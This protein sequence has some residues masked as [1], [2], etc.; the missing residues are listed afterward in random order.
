[1]PATRR[2]SVPA[3]RHPGTPDPAGRLA[4]VGVTTGA[5]LLAAGLVADLPAPLVTAVAVGP[6][7]VCQAI[8]IMSSAGEFTTG[9][10]IQRYGRAPRGQPVRLLGA[11]V[12]FAGLST[13]GAGACQ[14]LAPQAMVGAIHLAVAIP[15]IG[16]FL[17][18]GAYLLGLTSI[19]GVPLTLLGRLRRTL[20]GV[21]MGLCGFF[22]AWMLLFGH[23]GIRRASLSG[24]LLAC[25][26]F[27]GMVIAGLRSTTG[28]PAALACGGGIALSIAGMT[29]LIVAFD[30]HDPPNRVIA[31]GI[32][33]LIAPVLL[34]RATRAVAV[35]P[36][37]FPVDG[38]GDFGGYPLFALPLVAALLAWIDHFVQ[39]RS[40]DSTSIGLALAAVVA[41]TLRGAVA[42]FEARR[43]AGWLSVREAHFRS[44][45]SGSTDVIMV[46]DTDLRIR[47]QSPAAAR[48]FG[49][50]D[51]D[52][53]GR[54]F[55]GVVPGVAGVACPLAAM[56]AGDD[57]PTGP[58]EG[59]LLD[60]FGAWR[61]VEWSVIDHR[62]VPAV[63]AMVVHLRDV[64]DRKRLQRALRQVSLVDQVTGLPNR[65]ELSRALAR[66]RG[67]GVLIVLCLTDLVGVNGA[68]GHDVGDA[69]L[70]E[71]ARRI[72]A[73]VPAADLPV[74]LDSDRFAVLTSAMGVGA[75][76]LA[77]RLL[78][79]LAAP[80]P[81][82]GE[83]VHLSA[84]AGLAEFAPGRDGDEV[85]RRAE[86]AIRQ[87]DHADRDRAVEWYDPSNEAALRR[88]TM[89]EHA[90]RG[91]LSRVELDLSYQPVVDLRT[92]RP[93]GVEAILRWRHPVL[94][95]VDADEFLPAAERLG[96]AD[97]IGSWALHRAGREL[98]GWLR[99]GYDVWLSLDV[100]VGRL[101]SAMFVTSVQAV[102]ETHRLPAQ[103]LAV[104]V[105]ELGPTTATG[106]ADP[107]R[108][109][110]GGEPAA[111]IRAETA[112]GHLAELRSMG[113][114][115]AL[116]HFGTWAT[117]LSG[118]QAMPV[119]LLKADQSLVG[120]LA[121]RQEPAPAIIETVV[122]LGRQLGTGVIALGLH[123]ESDLTVA[124]A[125]G[126]RFGQGDRLCRPVPA[127]HLEAYLESHRSPRSDA[128]T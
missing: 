43:F 82:P 41:V 116:D 117:S 76:F 105:A 20:D 62:G 124:R 119:D 2:R 95:E 120:G 93:I 126:C 98:A 40:F 92:M 24:V 68:R 19:P 23:D 4:A 48:Q 36:P 96:L 32:S 49:L 26:A 72:R 60:G 13:A 59:R 85:L 31:S 70:A 118:L 83:P 67:H 18:A 58:V 65:R 90:L 22:V 87:V 46:L 74:R 11:G 54:P 33:L 99:C 55:S 97:E 25:V 69:V 80:Y 1:M 86:L 113:V 112:A 53:V 16:L 39:R 104:E 100:G 5:A 89:I 121:W 12:L 38:D 51:Q 15:L 66:R 108:R 50:S 79:I 110:R 57:R 127:E 107:A 81:L 8:A 114:L 64:G 52:V 35:G 73:G 47:W 56:A 29:Q 102:L 71:A 61:D 44:L 109:G 122:R 21:A 6:A 125:A 101:A 78:T 17:A 7:S 77:T 14:Y 84:V 3:G 45:F 88:Y 27:C 106:A 94:G 115:V 75:Q 111:A 63:A 123:T 34:R 91:L 9:A 103:R 37:R 10:A 42:S 128:D 28:R 30:Y